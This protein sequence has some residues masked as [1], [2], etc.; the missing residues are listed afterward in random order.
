MENYR[1]RQ[2][3]APPHYGE[4]PGGCCLQRKANHEL[5]QQVEGSVDESGEAEAL[6][7]RRTRLWAALRAVGQV[8]GFALS[9]HLVPE[10]P[11]ALS[12]ENRA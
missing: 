1:R 3:L 11:S 10:F 7:G 9:L 5:S 6:G 2:G 12:Q 4:E 8:Q